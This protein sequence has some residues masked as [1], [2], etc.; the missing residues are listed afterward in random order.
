MVFAIR[1][2]LLFMHVNNVRIGMGFNK[3]Y[4]FLQRSHWCTGFS[5]FSCY[6]NLTNACGV[7]DTGPSEEKQAW[8]SF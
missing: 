6:G 7:L 3:V 2:C 1:H 5:K 8:P 4:C